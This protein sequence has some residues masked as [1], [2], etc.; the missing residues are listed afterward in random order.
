MNRSF[1]DDALGN[2]ISDGSKTQYPQHPRSGDLTRPG[3]FC[4]CLFL[5]VCVATVNRSAPSPPP[6]IQHDPAPPRCRL[7]V[8]AVFCILIR[9][10]TDDDRQIFSPCSFGLYDC[11]VSGRRGNPIRSCRLRTFFKPFSQSGNTAT[12]KKVSF[13]ELV[14][15]CHNKG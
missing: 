4:C 10:M 2:I 1:T 12:E 9:R 11:F 7:V 5:L 15:V 14:S 8:V 6:S 13:R 3:V